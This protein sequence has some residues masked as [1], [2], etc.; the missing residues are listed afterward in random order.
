MGGGWKFVISPLFQKKWGCTLHLPGYRPEK[1]CCDTTSPE[2]MLR[3][4][5]PRSCAAPLPA[6]RHASY[7][8][9]SSRAA[10]YQPSRRAAY[11]QPSKRAAPLPAW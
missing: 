2:G 6:G 7:Y 9:P 10:Y 11:Y 8:Q 5:Q 3:H 1:A 4:Y